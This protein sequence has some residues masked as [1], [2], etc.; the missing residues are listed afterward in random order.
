M[1]ILHLKYALAVAEY[2]SINRA[3]EALAMNQPNLSRAVKDMEKELG[4]KLFV[5]SA[6]GML[7]TADGEL[8]LQK[9]AAL[10]KKADEIDNMFKNASVQKQTFS[11]AAPDCCYIC[12]AFVRLCAAYPGAKLSFS[13]L[14]ISDTIRTVSESDCRL[15]IIRF[16]NR[17]SSYYKQL[18]DENEL[19]GEITAQSE[20]KPLISRESPAATDEKLSPDM[21]EISASGSCAVTP[22]SR[23]DAYRLLSVRHDMYMLSDPI[24]EELMSRHGLMRAEN[25][26]GKSFT[27]M[28]IHKKN[29]RL[30]EIDGSFITFLCDIRRKIF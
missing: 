24:S 13:V 15:G 29:Y 7:P 17:H 16:D 28:L 5:R 4:T 11:L 27:D 1:N 2:G 14:N 10:M 21:I 3:A 25:F 19:D 9:A 6:R 8:F 12:D 26:P 20:Y 23:D 18:L 30:S 22:A